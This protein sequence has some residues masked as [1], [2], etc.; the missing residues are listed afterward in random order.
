MLILKGLHWSNCFSYGEDNYIPLTDSTVTQLIGRNGHGKSSIPL[1]LQEVLYNKNSKGIKKADVLNRFTNGK[2]YN[3][4][5]EFELEGEEYLFSVE[6]KGA[7]TKTEFMRGLEDI[8]AHTASATY[9]QVET[10]LGMDFKTFCQLVYQSTTTSLEFLT[11]TDTQRKNFLI[12]L[13]NLS[14]YTAKEQKLKKVY[15][16]VNDDCVSLKSSISTINSWLDRN[17]PVDIVSKDFKEVP[18]DP[19]NLREQLAKTRTELTQIDKTNKEIEE[20]NK[21]KVDI[22]DLKEKLSVGE[23]IKPEYSLKDISESKGKVASI[24]A[25]ASETKRKLNSLKDKCPTCLSSIDKDKTAELI[26]EQD[27]ILAK[28]D[29]KEGELLDREQETQIRT[30]EYENYHNYLSRLNSLQRRVDESVPTEK[31]SKG[32]LQSKIEE[33]EAGIALVERQIKEATE[34][35]NEI[36]KKQAKAELLNSQIEEYKEELQGK[37]AELL[38]SQQR[39][40]RL[41]ILKKAFSTKGIVAYKIESMTKD[42]EN[43]INE[44]LVEMSD[45]RFNLAFVVHGD[46][47]NV[48]L[49]DNGSKISIAALSSGEL[50]RVNISTLLAIRKL[51]NS[52]SSTK[53][54]LLFLDE[55]TSVLDDEGKERLVEILSNEREINSFIV[56]HGWQHPLVNKIQVIKENNISRVEW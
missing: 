49:L 32:S 55:V 44:Y 46:K 5:V 42:L 15:S 24:K 6:R 3:I 8:G 35:N 29:I 53:L 56:S 20:Q 9:K 4:A 23:P 43:L 47:L 26:E 51:M 39:R 22:A 36:S 50:A 1:I 10:L 33:L 17:K 30:L 37:E 18:P 45:G 54:N 16:E 25:T 38:Q 7:T 2:E 27:T 48:E 19:K 52:L 21:I 11:A 34:H 14:E 41:E 40:G 31:V 28:C 12:S 13:L